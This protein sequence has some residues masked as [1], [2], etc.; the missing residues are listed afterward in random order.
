MAYDTRA[1]DFAFGFYAKG[2]SKEKA[3]RE[4]RKVYPGFAGSTWD[5][6]VKSLDWEARRASLDLKRREF[7]ELCENTAQA[8]L[9]ELSEIRE[10][11]LKDIRAGKG[12][13][14]TVYAFN[15]VSKQ[16]VDLAKAHLV[17]KDQA[18]V[19]IV[20]LEQAIEKFLAGLRSIEGLAPALEKHASAIGKLAEQVGEEMGQ[21]YAA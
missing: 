19:S 13:T 17:N 12:D 9:L 10:G 20:I 5:S 8:I 2:L 15:A 3:L 18:K 14:Q 21:E 11:L 16:I 6:W 7:E 1:Q 4:I